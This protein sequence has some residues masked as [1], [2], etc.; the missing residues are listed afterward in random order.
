[1]SARRAAWPEHCRRR[2]VGAILDA[3]ERF[4]H[5]GDDEAPRIHDVRKA[6]KRARAAA[7]LFALAVGRPADEAVAALEAARRAT[8]RA[9]DLD[10]M[11]V[12]LASLGEAIEPETAARLNRAIAAER[13]TAHHAHRTIDVAGLSRQLR[14]LAG[15]IGDWDIGAGAAS[16]QMLKALRHA[17][18]AA[19]R[20]GRRALDSGD[21][22]KLHLLRTRIIDL[23][24]HFIA[25]EPVWPAML[26]AMSEEFQRMRRRL[27]EHHDLT[28]LAEFAADRAELPP[29]AMTDLTRKVE[30]RQRT[31]ARRAHKTFKRL[32]A[33]RPRALE[34]R[35]AA[36]LRYPK[37]RDP[38]TRHPKAGA[39]SASQKAEA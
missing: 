11:P 15:S 37:T 27:G 28:V 21:P 34:R 17:Y 24:E 6:L 29:S 36:C 18:R 32:F 3:A 16:G 8:G 10:V 20:R 33:E 4:P 26:S 25:L 23:G 39:D 31:L 30:R 35:L 1:M 19:R 22:R 14:E 38:E 5:S 13:E 7:R 9:R 2:L 12:A